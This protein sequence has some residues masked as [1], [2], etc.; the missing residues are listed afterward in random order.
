MGRRSKKTIQQQNNQIVNMTLGRLRKK[1]RDDPDFI[2]SPNMINSLT[3]YQ[4]DVT[5]AAQ[6]RL[7]VDKITLAVEE[8]ITNVDKRRAVDA[9]SDYEETAVNI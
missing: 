1:M 4:R 3:N 6:D 5:K 8:V 9:I 2:P 7:D